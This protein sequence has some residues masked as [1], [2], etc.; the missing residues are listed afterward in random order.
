MIRK[1][2]HSGQENCRGSLSARGI[3]G[4]VVSQTYFQTHFGII[5]PDG[6]VNKS[7]E[8]AVSSNVVSVLQAG[9]FFGA[10]GSA[11]LSGRQPDRFSTSCV[12]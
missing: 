12:Y 8:V 3:A 1:S 5:N 7:K 2:W 4:G 6:S 10:L 9:A 11:P